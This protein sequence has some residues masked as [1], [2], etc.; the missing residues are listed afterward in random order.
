M[1]DKTEKTNIKKK[2]VA[3]P[4]VEVSKTEAEDEG[5]LPPEATK[6]SEMMMGMVKSFPASPI[7]PILEKITPEHI[8]KLLDNLHQDDENMFNYSKSNR[9]FTAVYVL[10]ALAFFVFLIVFLLPNNKD[11]LI[12]L[13]K[14]G[15]A[16]AGGMGSGFGIKA[17]LDKR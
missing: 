6:I 10:I 3:K 17:Y 16:F 15:I 2:E 13:L 7:H 11:M 8:D 4:T 12:E 1:N 9:L 14:L 5:L